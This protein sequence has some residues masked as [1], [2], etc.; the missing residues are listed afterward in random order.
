MNRRAFLRFL[1]AAPIVGPAAVKA[2]AAT[3]LAHPIF[4]GELGVWQGVTIINHRE[5][6]KAAL[7]AWLAEQID[8]S[9]LEAM[10]DGVV[11]L[12]PRLVEKLRGR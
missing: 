11:Y 3:P 7:K 4:S 1:L 12:P 2:I 5:A 6:A 10:N 8:E 9:M